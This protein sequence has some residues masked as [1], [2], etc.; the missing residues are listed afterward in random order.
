M[1]RAIRK[2]LMESSELKLK[3]SEVLTERI[4]ETARTIIN[5]L[6]KGNKVL[7]CGNGGSAADCQHLAGE[8]VNRFRINRKPLPGLALTTDSS[9]LTCIGNDFS[10]DDI[11]S[12]QIEAFG[13][14]G[15][16]LIGISTSGN[17]KNVINAI[18]AAKEKDIFIVGFTGDSGGKMKELVDILINVPSADTPRIQEAHITIGHIICDLVEQEL[19]K[20]E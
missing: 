2:Q 4:E 6:R 10:F 19:F 3:V 11:F 14:K 20:N 18:N 15:D 12:K 1:E 8:F 5:S 16:V 7:F 17:S 13:A 9:V